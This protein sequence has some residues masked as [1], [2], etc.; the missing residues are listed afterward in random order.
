MPGAEEAA[1]PASFHKEL[2]HRLADREPDE[3][4]RREAADFLRAKL[5][6]VASEPGDLPDAPEGLVAWMEQNTRDVHARYAAYLQERKAGAPR[7]YFFNR[8][9]ALYVLRSVAPTKLV[10]GAWLYGL[11][12]H[13]QSPRL[14]DLVRTY[15]EELGEGAVDKNHVVLYRN[16]LARYALDPLDDLDDAL[17]EQ[18]L[19]QLALAWNAEAFLPE[20]VGFNLGYE[21]LPLHL[22]ITSYELNELGLDPYYFT[23][24]VTV[25]NGDTGHARRACQAVLDMLPR[26]DDGGAFWQRV[27]AGAKLSCAGLGTTDVI[28]S[29]DG[30]REALRILARKATAGHGAHS[31][32]CRVAGRSINDW[33]GTPQDMPG[34]VAALEQ[35]GWIRFGEPA[36]NSRF[37]SLLQGPR[38]E[39]F[40]VFSTYELQVLHDWMRGPA[41]AD[42]RPFTETAPAGDKP[43]RRATFRALARNGA[44]LA[45]PAD[46]A[47][48]PDLMLLR[49]QM[50]T[51]DDEQRTA[52]LVRAMSPAQHWTPAGLEATRV[53]WGALAG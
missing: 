40:G 30:E 50:R 38:A 35:A 9:H 42:G 29:F 28:A 15:V 48:D 18:G 13:W 36:E 14:G 52:L 51:A 41:S 53:F 32:Y 27:R 46:D 17:Y 47:L 8:A 21:Q 34:F 26:L 31:E 2:Y 7:R 33:L 45:A 11:L 5:L 12:P 24:H 49:E 3:G 20:V 23:L 37:W 6:D 22:L 44:G 39:M 43:K 1:G 10:D 4:T 16:L 25:D 19:I